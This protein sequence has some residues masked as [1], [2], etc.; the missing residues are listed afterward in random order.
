[1]GLIDFFKAPPP[2]QMDQS[3]AAIYDTVMRQ[4]RS[5]E[6][7]LEM[8]VPDTV[9]GRFDLLA[10]HMHMVLRRIKDQGDSAQIMGQKLFDAMFRD[11]DTQLR[12][13]G[14]GDMGIGK[15]IKKMA[16]GFYGRMES[17]DVGLDSEDE[18]ILSAALERNV[19]RHGLPEHP[20]ALTRLA[21]YVRAQHG[22]IESQTIDD[23]VAGKL[24]FLMSDSNP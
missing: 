5:P 16:Q 4:S 11:M 19:Y 24:S 1:M 9:D 10:V 7:Y 2:S 6:L 12:E 21:A 17:F 13:I 8:S 23:I 3:V 22:H 20:E 14:I 15:R 18:S